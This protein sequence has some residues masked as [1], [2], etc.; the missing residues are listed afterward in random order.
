MHASKMNAESSGSSHFSNDLNSKFQSKSTFTDNRENSILQGNF[1]SVVDPS[2]A[3]A[4]LHAVNEEVFQLVSTKDRLKSFKSKTDGGWF[5]FRPAA[6]KRLDTAMERLGNSL[7]TGEPPDQGTVESIMDLIVDAENF[8]EKDT[9]TGDESHKKTAKTRYQ[10]FLKWKPEIVNN[11]NQGHMEGVLNAFIGSAEVATRDHQRAPLRIGVDEENTGMGELKGNG[12]AAIN[13]GMRKDT[14]E[15]VAMF[16]SY[17]ALR[18]YAEHQGNR[19]MG[20]TGK[21]H[22]PGRQI[23][24]STVLLGGV[25]PGDAVVNQVYT[26]KGFAFFGPNAGN[27]YGEYRMRVNLN[28]VMTIESN[29]YGGAERDREYISAPGAQFRYLGVDGGTYSFEQV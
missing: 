27:Q 15:N 12:Y 23:R 25:A 28:K 10:G 2:S 20:D 26:E 7:D 1:A 4:Q 11:L 14:S 13:T 3:I 18:D 9:R 21:Y 29:M 8:L 17:R 16:D 24:Y 22:S 19:F 5:V 6:L